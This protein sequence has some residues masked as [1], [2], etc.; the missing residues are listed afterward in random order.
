[1]AQK[2]RNAT[3]KSAFEKAFT[4]FQNLDDKL[5]CSFEWY[6]ETLD[7]ASF[8][9]IFAAFIGKISQN[10]PDCIGKLRNKELITLFTI[11]ADKLC[12]DAMFKLQSIKK[13]EL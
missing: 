2:S 10:L 5:K 1:M 4:D 8:D 11:A 7:Q 6:N 9:F 12:L 13:L 3:K